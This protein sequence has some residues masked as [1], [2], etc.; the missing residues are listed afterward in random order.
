MWKK[1]SMNTQA[2]PYLYQQLD[3]LPSWQ[4]A[5]ETLAQR[6]AKH[7]ARPD[8]RQSARDYWQGL[9][10]PV[11][12]KNG[13]QLAQQ[14]GY[15]TPYK[16]Q[17][18]LGRAVWEADAVRD[19]LVSYVI[20]HLGHPEGILVLDESGFLKKGDKSCGVARQYW[21]TAGRIENCQIGVFLSYARAKGHTFLD[22]QLYLPKEW[23]DAP[24]RCR[25]ADVPEEVAF[26]TKPKIARQMLE[27]AFGAG[28]PCGWVTADAIYGN[29]RS[30]QLW[31]QQRGQAHVLAVSGQESVWVGWQ[32]HRVKDLLPQVPQQAWHLL[33]AGEGSKGPRLY[34][35]ARRPL[36]P[37]PGAAWE[38]WLLVRKSL[39]DPEQVNGYIAFAP[40]GTPLEKLVEV[41]GT[42]WTIEC[43]F[44][45]AKGEVGLDEYEVRSWHGWHRPITLAMLAH[46]LL[47]VLRAQ[48]AEGDLQKGPNTP[49]NSLRTFKQ[50]RGLW[51]A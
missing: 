32:Q 14:L 39:S 47:T 31:L 1:Q 29:D 48:Q 44:E 50:S 28:V 13:W 9:L 36:N 7:F 42:R 2:L 12:R 4:Q 33:S 27:R 25:E 45:A 21:G 5:L 26:A 34:A 15:A 16:V 30:L 11:E 19:E 6:I 40:T 35:W 22:R 37:A 43:C 51:C 38:R 20:E 41:A 24:A 23:T 46:A 3:P 17:H 8:A 49:G 10:S 18:L